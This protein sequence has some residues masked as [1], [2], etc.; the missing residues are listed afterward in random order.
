MQAHCSCV[1]LTDQPVVHLGPSYNAW[2]HAV[3]FTASVATACVHRVELLSWKP[4]AFVYHN[5]ITEDEAV[6]L[7]RL[8]APTVSAWVWVFCARVRGGPCGGGTMSAGGGSSKEKAARELVHVDP[9][10]V[11]VWKHPSILHCHTLQS[12]GTLSMLS[13]ANALCSTSIDCWL[14]YCC[15][16]CAYASSS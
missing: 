2:K 9:K 16:Q 11:L 12:A 3:V 1:V 6:Q 15:R 10:T 14:A 7:K 4:R 8:A 5:F 13:I